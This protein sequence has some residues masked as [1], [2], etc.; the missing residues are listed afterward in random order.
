MNRKHVLKL[1]AGLAVATFLFVQTVGPASAFHCYVANKPAG[2]GAGTDDDI[3]LAGQSGNLVYTGGAFLSTEETGLD[4]DIFVRGQPVPVG[5]Q[6]LGSLP[7]QPHVSGDDENGVQELE[8][9]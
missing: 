7:P 8:L 9:E 4:H 2:A 1:T 6:G 5:I 3:R